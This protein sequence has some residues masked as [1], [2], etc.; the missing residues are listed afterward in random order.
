M[1][2]GA[3]TAALEALSATLDRSGT[4]LRAARA[5]LEGSIRS[6]RWNGP[7][8]DR[9]GD[10]WGTEIEPALGRIVVALAAASSDLRRQA[11]HQRMV[12]AASD[13]AGASGHA[14]GVLPAAAERIR[15]VDLGLVGG[16]AVTA[17]VTLSF[18]VEDLAGG[19]SRVV[20]SV[21]LSAGPGVDAGSSFG[22]SVGGRSVA[23]GGTASVAARMN[24]AD[25]ATW[26]IAT[27]DLDA[28]L[29]QQ[30]AQAVGGDGVGVAASALAAVPGLGLTASV[31]GWGD[32]FHA[33]TYTIPPPASRGHAVGVTSSASA[34]IGAGEAGLAA[35]F[36]ARQVAGVTVGRDGSTTVRLSQDLAVLASAGLTAGRT[37]SV[38]TDGTTM[39]AI[40][41]D[42]HGQAVSLE[43]ERT[44]VDGGHLERERRIVDLTDPVV[45]HTADGLVASLTS[46]AGVGEVERRLEELVAAGSGAMASGSDRYRIG[47]DRDYGI[48]TPVGS[49]HVTTRELRL[50]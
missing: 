44:S 35:S 12:S 4:S 31:L 42:P 24:V 18:R 41:F 48:D 22:V 23:G 13:L 21:A 32:E 6:A 1:R 40:T 49:A 36:D 14:A 38:G 2:F 20:E 17:G 46:G 15:L 11:E 50:T 5:E 39:A 27:S 37:R 19:R 43:L 10:R 45:R 3:D 25:D 7:D 30:V 29:A 8:A 16:S 33:A 26:E 34:A 9:F 28:F 47:S